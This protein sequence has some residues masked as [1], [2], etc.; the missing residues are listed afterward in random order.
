MTRKT[1]W[2]VCAT[3]ARP[4]I[5]TASNTRS[6]RMRPA[7]TAPAPRAPLPTT[8]ATRAATP[9]PGDAAASSNV[10]ANRTSAATSMADILERTRPQSN[11]RSPTAT[12]TAEI[13]ALSGQ[14]DAIKAPPPSAPRSGDDAHGTPQ[15]RGHRRHRRMRIRLRQQ[16]A[17]HHADLRLLAVTGAH[18]GL[19]H[20]V[21]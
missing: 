8:R 15:W 17:D 2:K 11:H 1:S 10:L 9:G 21:G 16:H 4:R 19:L 13:N 3:T 12:A 6:P 20:Q 18:D 7:A 14:P 5:A